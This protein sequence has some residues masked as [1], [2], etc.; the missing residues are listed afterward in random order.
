MRIINLKNAKKKQAVESKVIELV[1]EQRKYQ[2]GVGTGKLYEALEVDFNSYQLKIGRDKLFT[3][4]REH[5]MLVK[6]KNHFAKQPIPIII[7]INMRI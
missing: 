6:R 7:F 5:D 2:P 4:L 1:K 3:I